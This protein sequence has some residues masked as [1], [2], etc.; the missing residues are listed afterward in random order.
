MV[1]GSQR[2][3]YCTSTRMG[4]CQGDLREAGKDLPEE[5]WSL[6]GQKTTPPCHL[7]LFHSPSMPLLDTENS[8]PFQDADALQ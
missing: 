3:A 7:R 8:Q 6:R 4:G 1:I 5:V 2:A